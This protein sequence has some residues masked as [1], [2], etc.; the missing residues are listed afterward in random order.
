MTCPR[1]ENSDHVVSVPTV[2]TVIWNWDTPF[3]SIAFIY[4]IVDWNG[5]GDK[6]RDTPGWN[7]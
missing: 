5:L 3:D 1:L 2:V 7:I 6:P 4:F